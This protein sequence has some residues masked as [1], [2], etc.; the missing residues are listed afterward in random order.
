MRFLLALDSGRSFA[1]LKHIRALLNWCF[2][3]DYVVM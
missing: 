2:F 1:V 3:L